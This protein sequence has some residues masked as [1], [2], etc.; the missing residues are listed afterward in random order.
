MKTALNAMPLYAVYPRNVWD[1]ELADEF[2]DNVEKHNEAWVWYMKNA[3]HPRY[4]I[5]YASND[6]GLRRCGHVIWGHGRLK[7]LGVLTKRWA[8]SSSH[9]ILQLT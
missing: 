6:E 2:D 3:G 4:H 9:P 5:N 7:D 8:G 1:N